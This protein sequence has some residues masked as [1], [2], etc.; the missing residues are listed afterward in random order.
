MGL[1]S[2][3]FLL[4]R[5]CMA[6]GL[7]AVCV[8]AGRAP[9]QSIPSLRGLAYDSLRSAPLAGAFI[10]LAG[11]SRSA[12]SDSAGRFQ[13]DSLATGTYTLVLHHDVLDS[14]GF[15]GRTARVT[16]GTRDAQVVIAVPS[17]PT[18]W[19]AACGGTPPRADSGFVYGVVRSTDDR[20]VRG[21]KVAV[22]W[23]DLSYTKVTGFDEK[24][25]GASIP[26]DSLGNFALCGVPTTGV[27]HLLAGSDS[28]VSDRVELGPITHRVARRDLLLGPRSAAAS[29]ARGVVTGI[30]SSNDG[31]LYGALIMAD[32]VQEGRS[33]ENGRF[34]LRDVPAGTRQIEIRAIGAE[35]ATRTV[36]VRP[37]DTAVVSVQL[38]KAATLPEVTVTAP[39]TRFMYRREIQERRE[40]GLGYFRDS[41]AIGRLPLMAHVFDGIAGINVRRGGGTRFVVTGKDDCRLAFFI[42]RVKMIDAFDLNL[43]A[44][45]QIATVEVYNSLTLAPA[46]YQVRNTCGAIVVWT[47]RFF[48]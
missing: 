6:S 46:E 36:D 34:W 8:V 7:L 33:D 3:T 29:S 25:W 22:A 21:V 30:V 40:L 41:T 10:S 13:F 2:P 4:R 14:V 31:P 17:F 42:D 23:N 20:P 5:G 12:I 27:L 39:A 9:A 38:K 1:P 24:S 28:L 16:V 43:L 26:V 44:P 37:G 18:L 15:S 19:R 48:R 45:D 11:S 47:K 32:E 35:P